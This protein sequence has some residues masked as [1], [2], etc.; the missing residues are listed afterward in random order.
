M[1]AVACLCLLSIVASAVGVPAKVSPTQ[2]VYVGDNVA[3]HYTAT[4]GEYKLFPIVTNH[5]SLKG[6]CPSLAAQPLYSGILPF[7]NHVATPFKGQSVL[8]HNPANGNYA[9]WKCQAF[10]HDLIFAALA[11]C[12]PVVEGYWASANGDKSIVTMANIT[13]SMDH[14][15]GTLSVFGNE[16]F[17]Q[18]ASA[19]DGS[20]DQAFAGIFS[21]KPLVEN[22][23]PD[24]KGH[25]LF[26]IGKNYV[27]EYSQD[28]GAYRTWV[29]DPKRLTLSGPGA[30]GSFPSYKPGQLFWLGNDRLAQLSE[31]NKMVV[32]R[33]DEGQLHGPH[34]LPLTA[35]GRST[36]GEEICH[37]DTCVECTADSNCGWCGTQHRCLPG[38]MEEP[39]HVG[40]GI[41]CQSWQF[42]ECSV[43]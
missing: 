39:C 24:F 35:I 7:K 33:M 2:I 34:P 10:E 21:V 28:T 13:L 29:F 26:G 6:R 37:Y 38:G 23:R 40:H 31:E 19:P 8:F 20:E 30:E 14:S 22:Y 32:M 12:A 16:E 1:R 11:P 4:T 27:I 43:N 3:L 15:T 42:G 9:V 25:H 17:D 36:L 41:E 5:P 18:L